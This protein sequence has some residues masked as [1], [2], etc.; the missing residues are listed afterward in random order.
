M[1]PIDFHTNT[2]LLSSQTKLAMEAQAKYERELMLHAADVEALQEVKKQ[3]Q[4]EA[5][6]KKELEEHLNKTSSLL[7]E[8]NA[9]WSALEKQLKVGGESGAH[10]L[11]IV[12]GKRRQFRQCMW[13]TN[14]GWQVERKKSRKFQKK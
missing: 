7:Q 12:K 5:E 1:R 2:S 14:N 10:R 13:R 3:L 11:K 6:R 4:R 9:S 8:K